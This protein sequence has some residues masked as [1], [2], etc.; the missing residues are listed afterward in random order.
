VRDSVRRWPVH[1]IRV[2]ATGDGSQVRLQDEGVPDA[3]ADATAAGW[4]GFLSK[5]RVLAETGGQTRPRHLAA[6]C[7]RTAVITPRAGDRVG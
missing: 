6:A 7:R 2:T 1:D 4:A 3:E 5:L